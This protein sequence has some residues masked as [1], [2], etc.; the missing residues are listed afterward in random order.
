[1]EYCC[2]YGLAR[3]L[4]HITLPIYV[5]CNILPVTHLECKGGSLH[6]AEY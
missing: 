2:S 5:E 4:Y 6:V 3:S 1:M